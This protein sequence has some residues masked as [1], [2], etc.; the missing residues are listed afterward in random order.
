[1]YEHFKSSSDG[2]SD[3]DNDSDLGEYVVSLHV[4]KLRKSEISFSIYLFYLQ[5]QLLCE[6]WDGPIESLIWEEM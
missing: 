4:R 3:E 2:W 6:Y 1:M 5:Q